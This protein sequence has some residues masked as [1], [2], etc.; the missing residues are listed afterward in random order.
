MIADDH[1]LVLDGIRRALEADGGFEIVGETQSGT[2][3]LPLVAREKP[4]LVLLDVRMPHM[5]GLACLDQIRARHPE[6]KVVMLSASSSPE[7][8]EAALRRG[9]SAYVIK[10]VEP[11]D[12]P[13]TLR[14]ALEGNVRTPVGGTESEPPQVKSLGLTERE[15]TIL[16]A[17]ARGLSNDE[18]A[19][20]LWVAPQ[21]VKFHLTNIYRKLGVKNRTEATRLAYQHGLVESPLYADD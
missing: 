14:Q 5:D 2:Q 17:L 16:G 8:V 19:K 12:L 4:D 15:L 7:L 3:V 10:T 20:E 9:A 18:I 13:A 11:N 1:R 21:T 6:V